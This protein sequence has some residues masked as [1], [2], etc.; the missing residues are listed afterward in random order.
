MMNRGI[1]TPIAI[2]APVESPELDAAGCDEGVGAD[3]TAVDFEF[4]GVDETAPPC[5]AV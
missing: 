1:T 5:D 2:F 4:G 3:E